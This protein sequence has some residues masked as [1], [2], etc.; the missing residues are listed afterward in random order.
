MSAAV[1]PMSILLVILLTIPF[2]VGVY[3]YR[4]ASRRGMNALLWALVAAFGPVLVG[5]II[6]LLVRGNYSD[7]RCPGCD[8]TV[9]EQFV[10]CPKCGIKLRA[11]CPNCAM[12]IEPDW[13]VCPKCTQ[14]LTGAYADIQPP[15]RA[16]DKSIGK[17]LAMVLIIPVLLIGILAFSF[18]ANFFGG[19]SS[20]MAES[21]D[22]YFEETN[23]SNYN[24][25]VIKYKVYHWLERVKADPSQAHALQYEYSHESGKEYF[26]LVFVPGADHQEDLL[27]DHRGSIF[28]TT[29]AL[30]LHSGGKIGRLYNISYTGKKAPNLKIKLDGKSFPCEVTTVD[31]NPTQFYIV[32]QYDEVDRG[33]EFFWLPQRITVVK[34]V[35]GHKEDFVYLTDRYMRYDILSSIDGAPYLDWKNDMYWKYRK[36]DISEEY[37]IKNG[38]DIIIEYKVEEPF[39]DYASVQHDNMIQCI[40]FEQQGSYY[41]IDDRQENGCYIREID[42]HL[43]NTL[44]DLFE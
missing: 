25:D 23:P 11:A 1:F 8:G 41:L 40:V 44:N 19:A 24:G 5:L 9:T 30:D 33:D 35:N 4:D 37:D 31:Y 3:V 22:E 42:E 17:I 26:L 39:E 29:L 15:V 18:S 32:P 16:K 2:V 20:L 6:Y 21:I 43:Y 7:L 13:K 14:P 34:L 36:N 10:V 12:P 28:G 27:M 38:F